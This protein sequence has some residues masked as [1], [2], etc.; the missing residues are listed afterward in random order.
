[1]LAFVKHRH[2]ANNFW[3]VKFRFLGKITEHFLY[4]ILSI[5]VTDSHMKVASQVL[6]CSQDL[7]HISHVIQNVPIIKGTVHRAIIQK[8]SC[9]RTTTVFNVLELF[10]TC[11]LS[12]FVNYKC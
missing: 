12:K 8:K 4:Q 1:M 10:L 2:L 7:W 3:A 11:S 9:R 5:Y 6:S